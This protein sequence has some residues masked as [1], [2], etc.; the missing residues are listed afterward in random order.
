MCLDS[1]ELRQW[2]P[3]ALSLVEESH[4]EQEH[5]LPCRIGASFQR[6]PCLPPTLATEGCKVE[7]RVVIL[8][9]SVGYVCKSLSHSV[10]DHP[11]VICFSVRKQNKLLG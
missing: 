10:K 6:D 2:A 3:F 11:S 5:P 4:A 1:V 9:A 7:F 8:C